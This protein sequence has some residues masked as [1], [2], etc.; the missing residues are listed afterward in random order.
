MQTQNE[1][2]EQ[3]LLDGNTIDHIAAAEKFGCRVLNSRISD[4]RKKGYIIEKLDNN[5][6]YAEHYIDVKKQYGIFDV[7]LGMY[8]KR[9]DLNNEMFVWT[10]NAKSALPLRAKLIEIFNYL[11]KIEKFKIKV[12]E[13]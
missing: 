3:Y 1:Q 6:N 2:I 4:L 7:D 11:R 5:K 9:V 13:L 10:F 8:L 12:V